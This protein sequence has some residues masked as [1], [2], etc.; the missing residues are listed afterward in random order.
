MTVVSGEW[1]VDEERGAEIRSGIGGGG[2]R[3]R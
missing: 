2:G 1:E 3:R